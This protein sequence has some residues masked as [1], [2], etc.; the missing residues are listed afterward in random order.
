MKKTLTTALTILTLGV[1]F[2][3]VAP[4]FQLFS[5][6][7]LISVDRKQGAEASDSPNKLSEKPK[8]FD[9]RAASAMPAYRGVP[10]PSYQTSPG[11]D[12][13]LIPNIEI[14]KFESRRETIEK[15]I[16]QLSLTAS[17]VETRILAAEALERLLP[18]EIVPKLIDLYKSTSNVKLKLT[19]ARTI[20]SAFQF[21]IEKLDNEPDRALAA[22]N[23]PQL[24]SFIE[25][26]LKQLETLPDSLV[27]YF[28]GT[29]L[30][31]VST[32]IAASTLKNLP[33]SVLKRIDEV[34]IV[35]VF[36][37]IAMRKSPDQMS[38]LTNLISK[39]PSFSGE[40]QLRME[41]LI[42]SSL[43]QSTVTDLWPKETLPALTEYLKQRADLAAASLKTDRPDH[44]GFSR[45]FTLWS[46]SEANLNGKVADNATP[47]NVVNLESAVEIS[48]LIALDPAMAEKLSLEQRQRLL[49]LIDSALNDPA[50]SRSKSW[51]ER[52]AQSLRK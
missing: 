12:P 47:A 45:L 25:A 19:I 8:S 14:S 26:N 48:S 21:P 24:S 29:V 52:A 39:S 11:R 5:K 32:D 51:L 17:D 2:W 44:S 10:A 13:V 41:A 46:I 16:N 27:A 22:K 30:P 34:E 33:P 35:N 38:L 7:D 37:H 15:L 9:G 1:G 43:S 40:A 20:V 23:Y 6:S 49:R 50:Y 28:V 42:A 18:I 3:Y 31:T 36:T 4:K